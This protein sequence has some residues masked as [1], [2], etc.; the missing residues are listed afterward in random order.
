MAVSAM[1]GSISFYSTSSSTQATDTLSNFTRFLEDLASAQGCDSLEWIKLLQG[2]AMGVQCFLGEAPF[3]FLSGMLG[4]LVFNFKSIANNYSANEY[5]KNFKQ[6]W[7][8]SYYDNDF[9]GNGHSTSSLFVPGEPVVHVA[10][11]FA[12]RIDIGRLL[13]HCMLS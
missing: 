13:V 1:V 4:V 12:Q 9:I 7:T 11:R 3:L 5:R 8:R 10:Y 6:A 2:L